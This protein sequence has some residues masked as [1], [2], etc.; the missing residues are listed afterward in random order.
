MA[1]VE[2]AATKEGSPD[3]VPAADRIA[4]F[5]GYSNH[6]TLLVRKQSIHFQQI[7][8]FLISLKVLAPEHPEWKEKESFRLSDQ[9]R[10]QKQAARSGGEKDRPN[11]VET[12]HAGID[13]GPVRAD[14]RSAAR[15]H[16]AASEIILTVTPEFV[17]EPTSCTVCLPA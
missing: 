4:T 16:S 5:R 11:W 3:F 6:G 1:F 17:H 7:H 2:K 12:T 13:R 14:G 10:C 9:G 8:P 15:I